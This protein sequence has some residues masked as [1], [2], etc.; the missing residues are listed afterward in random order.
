MRLIFPSA[1]GLA[2]VLPG[3][4]IAQE[5]AGRLTWT[6]TLESALVAAKEK[7]APIVIVVVAGE[8]AD[9]KVFLA[10]H[11]DPAVVAL[12]AKTVNVVAAEGSHGGDA[13]SPCPVFPG[14]TCAQHQTAWREVTDKQVKSQRI[15]P[16]HIFLAPGGKLLLKRGYELAGEELAKRINQAIGMVDR[17]AED[18]PLAD[19]VK[20][21]LDVLVSRI[22]DPEPEGRKSAAAVLGE[23]D[24]PSALLTVKQ[25]L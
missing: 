11:A 20:F 3:G 5:A 8:E 24:V 13:T 25:A 14:V 19:K 9:R 10:A 23:S 18:K 7:K 15:V 12:L 2:L 22:R 17:A 16:Q 1:M 21:T 4:V 6:P